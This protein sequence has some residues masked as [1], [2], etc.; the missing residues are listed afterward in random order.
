MEIVWIYLASSAGN[1]LFYYGNIFEIFTIL[2]KVLTEKKF[3][4]AKLVRE[5]LGRE[6]KTGGKTKELPAITRAVR[7]TYFTLRTL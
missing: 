1:S 7:T 2:D 4:R 3:G 6:G 5:G